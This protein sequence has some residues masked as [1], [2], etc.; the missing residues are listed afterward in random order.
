MSEGF[1]PNAQDGHGWTPLHFAAQEGSVDGIKA[2][3][4][5]HAKVGLFD[6]N[7]NTALFRAVFNSNGEGEIISMLL[8]AGSDPDQK[9]HHGVSPR[10]LAETI[11]NY[12]VKQFFD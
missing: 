12:D 7:G 2:L 6:A 8:E 9:N 3:L 11:G 5:C 10:I 4:E 1:D